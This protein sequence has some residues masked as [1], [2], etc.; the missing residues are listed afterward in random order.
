[1]KLQY[2]TSAY[3]T[4]FQPLREHWPEYLMEGA[5]LGLYMM[6]AGIF[7]V[8]LQ[9]YPSPIHGW[10]K[11][12]FFRRLLYGLAMGM[13]STA[14]VYSPWGRQSGAHANSAITFTYWRLGKIRTS[15]ALFY[16]IAQFAGGVSGVA[17]ISVLFGDSF[18]L[19]PVRYVT[20]QPGPEGVWW[21][22]AAELLM[23]FLFMST[24]LFVTNCPA[25]AK[26]TGVFTGSLVALFLTFEAPLSGMSMNPARTFSSALSGWLWQGTWA[27]F[28]GPISGMLLAVE[29]R[30]RLMHAPMRACAKLYHDE[31]TR[32]IFCG[33]KP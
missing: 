17:F 13:T 31:H 16:A 21:A 14:L 11:S 30:K 3:E 15:D 29:V 12:S 6:S 22:L 28:V 32:C 8:L 10:I 33:R 18:R 23:S 26:H 20:T 5:L 25:L 2:D 7:A 19:P 9:V 27:Y 1:M 24:I 4:I